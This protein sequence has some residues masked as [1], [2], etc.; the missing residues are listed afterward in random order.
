MG[1]RTSGPEGARQ[2]ED[3]GTHWEGGSA[4]SQ[5][6]QLRRGERHSLAPL[7]RALLRAGLG[8]CREEAEHG[9]WEHVA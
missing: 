4:G 9:P 3:M 1:R 5:G 7:L 6:S 2:P 8:G